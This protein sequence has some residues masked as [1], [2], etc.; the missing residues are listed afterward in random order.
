MNASHVAYK[1]LVRLLCKVVQ[2]CR[3]DL[4][5]SSHRLFVAIFVV[6]YYVLI[7][8]RLKAAAAKAARPLRPF[9]NWRGLYTPT[10][11]PEQPVFPRQIHLDY[12]AKL[13]SR[14]RA[15]ARRIYPALNYT[16][17]R[18]RWR[19]SSAPLGRF[20]GLLSS[21]PIL[22]TFSVRGFIY[23]TRRALLHGRLRKSC[24]ALIS[25]L[26]LRRILSQLFPSQLALSCFI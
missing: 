11:S 12:S 4:I 6:I 26:H 3:G 18:A 13:L 7:K 24:P 16:D 20:T 22:I 15:R 23:A 10:A 17:G 19:G 5:Y 21:H 1:L 2:N 9:R 25:V 14:A 8:R